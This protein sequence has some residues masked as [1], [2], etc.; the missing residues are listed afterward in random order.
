M[1]PLH[2]R[3]PLRV[4]LSPMALEGPV[5]RLRRGLSLT[6]ETHTHVFKRPFG[7]GTLEVIRNGCFLRFKY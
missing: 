4:I 7:C 1:G 6:G 2:N 5:S 3:D